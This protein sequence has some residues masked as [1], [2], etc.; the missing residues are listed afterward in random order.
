M[1]TEQERVEFVNDVMAKLK[2]GEINQIT[3]IRMIRS[4]EKKQMKP[5]KKIRELYYCPKCLA[6]F[7]EECICD[8]DYDGGDDGGAWSGGFADNH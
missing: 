6:M 7:K 8:E 5:K 2:K 1:K 3:A 4:F